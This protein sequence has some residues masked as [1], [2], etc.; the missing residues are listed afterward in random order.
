MADTPINEPSQVRAG[1]SVS[2]SKEVE[3]YPATDSYTLYYSLRNATGLIDIT[4]GPDGGGYL[5]DLASTQ[6]TGWTAG[7][8]DWIAYVK[9]AAERHTVDGG[10]MEIL[11]NLE[12]TVNYDARSDARV[13]YDNLI[14]A[15]KTY[16]EEG[17]GH[18]VSMSIA[19][20]AM[21]FR[22]AQDFIDQIKYWENKV[23][24]EDEAEA[25]AN[26]DANP[27]RVGIRFNRL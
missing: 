22:N 14:D 8:Y 27:R 9:K 11:P 5:V 3:D 19:G 16:I 20:K 17:T 18:V 12:N 13:I 1:D 25:I 10:R 15:Y 4:A 24:A 23:R 21:S 2:W 7:Y 6:T 26:N